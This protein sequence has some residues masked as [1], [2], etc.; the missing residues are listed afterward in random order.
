MQEKELLIANQPS[1]AFA[2]FSERL[3]K[4]DEICAQGFMSL[5][6]VTIKENPKCSVKKLRDRLAKAWDF[7]VVLSSFGD[8]PKPKTK[9]SKKSPVTEET[10][11]PNLRQVG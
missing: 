11:Q 7:K 10:D 5:L 3:I 8:D 4:R 6:E 1:E 2:W 9:K